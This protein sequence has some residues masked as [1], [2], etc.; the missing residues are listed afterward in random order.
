MSGPGNRW[1]VD[2]P[3]RW[4]PNIVYDQ[5]YTPLVVVFYATFFVEV[6]ILIAVYFVTKNDFIP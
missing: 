1:L 4:S 2:G 3:C 5:E 6:V